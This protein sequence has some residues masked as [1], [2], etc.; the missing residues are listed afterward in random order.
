MKHLTEERRAWYYERL[1]AKARS[2]FTNANYRLW[3]RVTG[4][5][6]PRFGA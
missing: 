4:W 2:E 3:K 5:T 1:C 6:M